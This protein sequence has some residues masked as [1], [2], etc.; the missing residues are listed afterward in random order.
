MKIDAINKKILYLLQKDA[1]MTYK[2]IATELKRSETTIRDR[3]K[4]MERIGIIQG[5]TAL[6]NKTALG[7]NFFAILLINPISS[8]EIDSITQKIKKVK[9]VVR[10]YEISGHHRLAVFM[11]APSYAELKKIVN[12]QLLP[13]GLKDEEIITVLEAD[14]E[15][16]SPLEIP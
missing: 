5:Y 15:F 14:T 16:I 9:N 2:E 13:I 6:I 12:K 8:S 4:A 1:R 7:I 10:L 11:V 3:I